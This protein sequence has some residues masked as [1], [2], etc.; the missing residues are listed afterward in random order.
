MNKCSMFYLLNYRETTNIFLGSENC[1][2]I[3]IFSIF[4]KIQTIE[5]KRFNKFKISLVNLWRLNGKSMKCSNL[6]TFKIQAIMDI[7]NL[8]GVADPS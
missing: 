2:K 1:I 3:C 6:L 5:V 4:Y 8:F 7:A